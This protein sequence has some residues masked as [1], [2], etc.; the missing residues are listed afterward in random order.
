MP[1]FLRGDD[2]EVASFFAFQDIITAVMG[3]LILIALQLSF[4]IN[5]VKGEEGNKEG[6][7]E[8]TIISEEEFLENESKRKELENRLVQL[9]AE[10]RELMNT[11]QRLQSAGQSVK[12]LENTMQILRAEVDQ[13]TQDY[14]DFR[15]ALAQKEAALQEQ[16]ANLGL[17]SV[18]S[19]ISELSKKTEEDSREIT[20]LKR[21]LQILSK[22]LTESMADLLSEK[23]KHDSVWMIPERSNDGKSPLL[24]TIDDD[25]MRFEEFNK[26]ESLRVLSTS[27]LSS[28]FKAGVKSYDTSSFKIVFLFKPSGTDYF[29]KIIKLAKDLGFEIGYDPIEESQ[30]V[31]FSVPD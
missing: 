22:S 1:D 6:S 26:P 24:L 5:V 18:Q 15:R 3:I 16:S 11:K 25:N 17:S 9:R 8:D 2:E 19:E 28:S 31:I 20:D 23:R 7:T 14:E 12:G 10:N 30:Q 13:L 27:S 21:R 29:D 4:S